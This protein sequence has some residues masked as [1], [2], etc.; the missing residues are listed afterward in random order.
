MSSNDVHL[1]MYS[2]QG[3][4]LIDK[5]VNTAWKAVEFNTRALKTGAYIVRMEDGFN[6]LLTGQLIKK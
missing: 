4:L 5:K 1:K 6:V 3:V 2:L